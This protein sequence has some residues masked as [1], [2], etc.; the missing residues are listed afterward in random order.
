MFNRS[1][2]EDLRVWKKKRNRKP[3]ILRGARQVGKTTAINI[4]DQDFENYVEIN[5]EKMADNSLFN[6]TFSIRDIFQA[7]LL[8]K[9]LSLQP[10]STLLFIDEI[11]NSPVALKMLRYFYEEMPHIHVVAAGSLLEVVLEKHDLS[12]PVGRVEYLYMYPV[13]FREFLQ[14]Q[15]L[16]QILEMSDTV[17]LPAIS[18][19]PLLSAF[20]RYSII[21]GM[22]EIIKTYLEDST[23]S[24]LSGIYES[25]TG[26]Y[27]DDVD[28]YARHA[29]MRHILKHCIEA[30]P[31]ESGQR[32]KF[33]GFG[34]SNYR[35]REVGEALRTLE[36]AMLIYLVYPTT[37]VQLPLLSD[38]K[39]SPKLQFID[40]GLI[41]YFAGL[42]PQ[43]F[44]HDD[45]LAIYK[46]MIAEHIL[47][48]EIIAA[49]ATHNRVPP[50][51]VRESR[52]SNAEVDMVL[53]H[54]GLAIPVE[55][56]AGKT[57][58]LRSLHQFMDKVEHPFA[59][60]LYRGPLDITEAATIQ[61][62]KFKLLNLPYFL[63][64]KI[65]DYI[66]WF[67]ENA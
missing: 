4:F 54:E 41:N 14:A 51:W 28:R 12:F 26:S 59:V 48:Q 66:S 62:K 39:K 55:V 9:N 46:G 67:V 50:F 13:T 3:L 45:L 63:A 56:K 57:G 15:E 6:A 2:L 42:Q 43:F 33:H 44:K 18:Y 47:R 5:L 27:T 34:N 58:S 64:G 53:Q 10:G 37:A 20:H 40:T 25:L 36:R 38:T 32:I 1:I 65:G 60:R 21:G 30:T 29:S 52:S 49:D 23:L 19:A 11:Q 17:P 24:N 61:G 35:T 22:P 7:I 31:L 16:M 8:S